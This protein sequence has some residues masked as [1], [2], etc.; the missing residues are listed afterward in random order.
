MVTLSITPPSLLFKGLATKHTSV[1]WIIN[2]VYFERITPLEKAKGREGFLLKTVVLLSSS[3]QC[4]LKEYREI[5]PKCDVV[6][7]DKYIK[8]EISKN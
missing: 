2:K 3:G 4:D 7:R 8:A 1:N 6:L 5:S